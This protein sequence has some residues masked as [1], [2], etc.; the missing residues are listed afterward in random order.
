ME[1][2]IVDKDQRTN[3]ITKKIIR[4]ISFHFPESK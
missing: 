3:I 2:I 1:F 4:K